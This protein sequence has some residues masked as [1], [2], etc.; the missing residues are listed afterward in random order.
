MYDKVDKQ[1]LKIVEKQ[2]GR[3]DLLDVADRGVH[4]ISSGEMRRVLIARAMVLNP[5][6]LIFD[7]ITANLDQVSRLNI[8]NI[9]AAL[10]S[11]GKTM[12]LVG[13]HHQELTG[14]YNRVL[15]MAD[16]EIIS[17]LDLLN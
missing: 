12:I 8:I 9:I 2:L 10:A 15:N 4:Q 7:E 14:L 11:Q 13:H 1:Q 6:I 3:F 17:T 5:E 16:G